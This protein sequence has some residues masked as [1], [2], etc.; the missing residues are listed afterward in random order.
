MKENYELRARNYLTRRTPVIIR[1]DQKAGHTFTK[2]LEKPFDNNYNDTMQ[3]AAMATAQEIQ[4]CYLAYH[5][6]DEISFL[7]QD[8]HK[9]ETEAWFG[10]NQSKLESVT[11]S[12]VTSYFNYFWNLIA[13]S[14]KVGKLAVFDARGV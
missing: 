10:Y 4:G 14:S 1:V 3:M 2:G 11:A 7:L 13:D 9:V 12:L 6:S 8:Y 5:Q